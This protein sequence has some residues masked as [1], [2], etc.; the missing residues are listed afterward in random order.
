MRSKTLKA[1]A[2]VAL[3]AFM[4]FVVIFAEPD[5][6]IAQLPPGGG[7]PCE[8]MINEAIEEADLDS[9]WEHSCEPEEQAGGVYLCGAASGLDYDLQY[10]SAMGCVYLGPIPQ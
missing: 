6:A 8:T 3:V 5:K 9:V 7:G 10:Q 4:M 1:T 2:L